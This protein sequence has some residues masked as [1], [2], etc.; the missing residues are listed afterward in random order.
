MKLILFRSTK[1]PA[2]FAFTADTEGSNLP[3]AFAPWQKAGVGA[4]GIGLEGLATFGPVIE[5]VRRDGYFLAQGPAESV[6]GSA[7]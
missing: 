1:D 6:S 5:A 3:L 4:I 2:T 7:H